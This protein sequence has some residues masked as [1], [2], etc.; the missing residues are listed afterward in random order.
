M[1]LREF[2]TERDFIFFSPCF[3]LVHNAQL[4]LFGCKLPFLTP[5]SFVFKQS[6]SLI[7]KFLDTWSIKTKF[8]ASLQIQQARQQKTKHFILLAQDDLFPTPL[9]LQLFTSAINGNKNFFFFWF[10]YL[11]FLQLFT[12]YIYLHYE[13]ILEE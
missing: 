5:S 12:Y 10:L 11:F 3:L 2:N 8:H 1:L 13:T 7:I 9:S 4:K 6:I